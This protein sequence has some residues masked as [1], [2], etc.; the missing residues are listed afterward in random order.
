MA[1]ERGVDG[2]PIVSSTRGKS[3]DAFSM[4]LHSS[5][6]ESFHGEEGTMECKSGIQRS[7]LG[8]ATTLLCDFGRAI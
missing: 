8:L 2:A 5:V 7:G 6:F 4:F 3:V 1:W